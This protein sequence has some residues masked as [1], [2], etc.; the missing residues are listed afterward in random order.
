MEESKPSPWNLQAQIPHALLMEHVQ[1]LMD[2][3]RGKTVNWGWRRPNVVQVDPAM[4][5][6]K[7]D[8]DNVTRM[9]FKI[10]LESDR[11]HE[12]SNVL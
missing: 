2:S 3:G 4:K 9:A 10:F 11:R 1:Q 6:N 12:G 7:T 5:R 8:G